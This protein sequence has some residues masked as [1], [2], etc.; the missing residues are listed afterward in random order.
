VGMS[1]R[2]RR[3]ATMNRVQWVFGFAAVAA[4]W[5]LFG[6]GSVD[7]DESASEAGAGS[8]LQAF[9]SAK[10]ADTAQEIGM[11]ALENARAALADAENALAEARASADAR[12][13]RSA[14]KVRKAAESAAAEV[15]R[16]VARIGEL[17]DGAKQGAEDAERLAKDAMAAEG[18]KQGRQLAGQARK[19]AAGTHKLMRKA[20]HLSEMLKKRWLLRTTRMPSIRERPTTTTTTI[21]FVTPTGR[22]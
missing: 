21:P 15:E 16:T 13:T 7:T 17:A 10:K 1:N 14:E 6:W 8:A 20:V 11:K 5:S 2:T 3:A 12:R 19:A 22:D 4:A 18:R 9:E